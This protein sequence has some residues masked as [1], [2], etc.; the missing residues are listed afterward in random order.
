ML[1][2]AQPVYTGPPPEAEEGEEQP[3]TEVRHLPHNEPS[4]ACVE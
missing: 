3:A 4:L 2:K 1:P